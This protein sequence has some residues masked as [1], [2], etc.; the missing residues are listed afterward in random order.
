MT[1]MVNFMGLIFDFN[2][3]LLWDDPIQRRSW[4]A[5]AAQLRDAPLT[6]LEI[7]L[8]VHGRSGRYTVEYLVGHPIS[9]S[10]ADALTEEK[11]IGR[12]HV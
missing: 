7:D 12:A 11:E 10:E 4:R 5:F 3:V 9:Q 1:K 8:H 6:D 2:G